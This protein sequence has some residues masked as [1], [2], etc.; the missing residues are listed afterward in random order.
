MVTA[1]VHLERF[2]GYLGVRRIMRSRTSQ[3]HVPPVSLAEFRVRRS[4]L[5]NAPDLLVVCRRE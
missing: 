3:L 5:S 1:A 4:R 2:L